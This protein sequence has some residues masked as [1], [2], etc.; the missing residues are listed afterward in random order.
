MDDVGNYLYRI[1]RDP[2]GLSGDEKLGIRDLGGDVRVMFTYRE[3]VP[4]GLFTS[5][6]TPDG[7]ECGG[8]VTFDVPQ[9]QGI[10]G[11]RWTLHSLDPLHLEPSIRCGCGHHGWIREG[12]W[13]SA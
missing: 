4:V 12:Q 13:V 11:P 2:E 3:S 10:S 6:I 5:H 7:R 9:A 1:M 8:S